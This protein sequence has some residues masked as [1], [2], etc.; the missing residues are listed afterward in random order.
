MLTL[1]QIPHMF[2]IN[3]NLMLILTQIPH[4]FRNRGKRKPQGPMLRGSSCDQTHSEKGETFRKNNKGSYR[5]NKLHFLQLARNTKTA[6]I[7]IIF[8][9][10]FLIYIYIFLSS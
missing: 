7:I 2:N 10:I 8:F 1:T 4:M 5:L 3:F 9:M 6:Y